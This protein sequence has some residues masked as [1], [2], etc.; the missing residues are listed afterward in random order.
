MGTGAVRTINRG[1]GDDGT[2][3]TGPLW[4]PHCDSSSRR[5]PLTRP[6][7]RAAAATATVRCLLRDSAALAALVPGAL[8]A[9]LLAVI[10][11]QLDDDARW[12]AHRSETDASAAV[13]P[14]GSL[15]GRFRQ[16]Q[17]A[18]TAM[19]VFWQRALSTE[20]QQVIRLI[21]T[22]AHC[23]S[24][25]ASFALSAHSPHLSKPGSGPTIPSRPTDSILD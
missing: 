6:A 18:S 22:S 8:A 7:P 14:A 1:E 12:R 15:D 10:A 25:A 23:L 13:G 2:I 17:H 21:A 16:H 3:G 9:P 20:R 24:L 11:V 4:L 5:A 19:A